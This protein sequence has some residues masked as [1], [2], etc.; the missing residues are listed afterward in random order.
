M[1]GKKNNLSLA[2]FIVVLICVAFFNFSIFPK[3]ILSWDVFGYYMYLPLI[4]IYNNWGLQD[5]NIL[6]QILEQYQN[7]STL[8]QAYQAEKGYWVMVLLYGINILYILLARL[9]SVILFLSRGLG[10]RLL[11][12][13][14]L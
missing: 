13:V 2:V 5:V 14:T 12:E 1:P 8:Y 11:V 9:I 7:S 3:N 4:F 10:F 6:Y